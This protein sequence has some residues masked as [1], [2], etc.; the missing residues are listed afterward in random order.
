MS[1]EWRVEVELTDE[2]HGLSLGE[3]LR[4]M[5]LNDEAQER[6]GGRV[7]VTREGSR[8]FLYAGSESAAREAERVISE[9]AAAEGLDAR[10]EIE[11]WDPGDQ[12]WEDISR[13]AAEHE[14][15]EREQQERAVRA[16]HDPDAN[17]V[18]HPAFVVIGAHKPEILRDLGL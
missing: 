14:R 5:D 9:L 15:A 3:R 1:D 12:A 8:M 7:I 2:G 10:T 13:R 6:L 16:E 18:P 11:Q 17:V 4:S